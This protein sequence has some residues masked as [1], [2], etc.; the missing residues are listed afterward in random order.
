[1]AHGVAGACSRVRQIVA[2]V[3]AFLDRE[4]IEVTR[5][6]LA[7]GYVGMYLVEVQL[8]VIVTEAPPSF[9]LKRRT[10]LA[11]AFAFIW[12]LDRMKWDCPIA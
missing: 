5:A 1:M 8:P 9:T 11:T 2:T 3:R 4:P 10:S 7:P 6:T 12:S